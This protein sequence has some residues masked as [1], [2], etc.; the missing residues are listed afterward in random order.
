MKTYLKRWFV[1]NQF[2]HY[3][4]KTGI[5][6]EE[7]GKLVV[8]IVYKYDLNTLTFAELNIERKVR[9]IVK[10]LFGRKNYNGMTLGEGISQEIRNTI[11]DCE[12]VNYIQKDTPSHLAINYRINLTAKGREEYPFTHLIYMSLLA[13]SKIWA[14]ILVIISFIL[15]LNWHNLIDWFKH[16]K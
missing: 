11:S 4:R 5:Q 2:Y 1:I 10:L 16:L 3:Q 15:G 8:W 7:E 12:S 14:I 13:I 6:W 9:F